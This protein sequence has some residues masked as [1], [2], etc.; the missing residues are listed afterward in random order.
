M[1]TSSGPD[2]GSVAGSVAE[3][4]NRLPKCSP[5]A[6]TREIVGDGEHLI[7]YGL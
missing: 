6:Q 2:S 5:A 3:P 1:R 7:T 4:L